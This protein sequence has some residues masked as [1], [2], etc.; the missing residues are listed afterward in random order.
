MR[1]LFIVAA[2]L[3]F[4][5]CGSTAASLDG[6]ASAPVETT[7]PEA[8]ALQMLTGTWTVGQDRLVLTADGTYLW[9]REQ[10][11]DLPPCPIDQTSG[12]FVPRAQA[13]HLAT[14]AGPELVLP[15]IISS[16]PRRITLSHPDGRR[17]TLPFV[18]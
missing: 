17:W 3:L 4:A 6:K 9:E 14:V 15:Y 16:D 18:E 7:S 1:A 11:C 13:L 10:A 5:A 8:L 12:S 2:A